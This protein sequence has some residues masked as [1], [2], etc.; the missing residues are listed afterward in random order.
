MWLKVKRGS[1]S[2]LG[3][4]FELGLKKR[5]RNLLNWGAKEDIPKRVKGQSQ[6]SINGLIR[7]LRNSM[8]LERNTVREK[9]RD[10]VP[11]GKLREK[12]WW[13]KVFGLHLWWWEAN[14]NLSRGIIWS[15]W[16]RMKVTCWHYYCWKTRLEAIC[17]ESQQ[18]KTNAVVIELGGKTQF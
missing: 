6:K 18:K 1:E 5:R 14:K 11:R 8:W 2:A 12:D 4:Q 16:Y 9:T 10:D 15:D 13:G 7:K 3:I 17:Y